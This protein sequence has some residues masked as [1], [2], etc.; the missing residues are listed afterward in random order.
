MDKARTAIEK[1]AEQVPLLGPATVGV[2]SQFLM[3]AYQRRQ[4]KWFKEWA[5]DFDRLEERVASFTVED[6]V[7]DEAFISAMIQATRVAMSTH[8]EEKRRALRHALLN[9]ALSPTFDEEKQIVFLTLI[10]VL[11]VTHLVLLRLFSNRRAFP[12]EPRV[13]LMEQASMTNPMIL[14]LTNRGLLIDPRASVAKTRDTE[15]S[16]LVL[17]WLPTRLGKEFLAFITAPE[18]LG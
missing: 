13:R 8:Q 12:H 2:V 15:G 18:A 5:D 6:I 4:E 7:Q 14:D 17:E 9:I 11:T 10:E 1:I 3:P 16:L